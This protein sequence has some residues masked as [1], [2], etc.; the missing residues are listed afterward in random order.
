[1]DRHDICWHEPPAPP[2]ATTCDHHCSPRRRDDSI[3]SLLRLLRRGRVG[4]NLYVQIVSRPLH[5]AVAAA[6]AIASHC[7]DRQRVVRV[8][9]ARASAL[10][11]RPGRP[12]LLNSLS[13]RPIN[14][15]I[16][17]S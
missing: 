11:Y 16:R 13:T 6:T 9:D 7:L 14:G 12:I 17:L 5:T 15:Y 1:M 10:S 2:T 3:D 8:Q 4:G